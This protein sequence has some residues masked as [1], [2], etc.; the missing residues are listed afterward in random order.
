LEPGLPPTT[1]S[2]G[3]RKKAT[4]TVKKVRVPNA[5][6][7]ANT[8]LKLV[9]ATIQCLYELGYHQTST[10][11]V[12]KRA[13]VSRGAMLHHFP[14][15]ADLMM[16][17]MDY[18]R[19]KRGDAHRKHLERFKTEREQ[20]LQLIDVLW[21]EFQTPTGVARIELMLGSR[22]DPDLRPR[23]SELNLEL[24]RIHKDRIWARAEK[25]G[26]KD[27]KKID[28]F[29]QLY[30]AALRGLAI[31][32]LWPQSMP[33]IKGAVALLKEAQLNLLDSLTSGR[34]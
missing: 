10:V 29:V 27:R 18:I 32:A 4:K 23:F 7:S 3:S 33:D 26:I 15:K 14:S 16:A 8:R 21:E 6:R 2:R 17:A 31:D 30:A 24:E 5:E 19:S 12:T 28:A 25:L 9:E 1:G 34:P 11:V 20:F 13:K 22:N